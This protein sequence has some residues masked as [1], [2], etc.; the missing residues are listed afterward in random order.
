MNEF[1][2]GRAMTLPA[3]LLNKVMITILAGFLGR[4][5]GPI[6]S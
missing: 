3:Q 5:G 1:G 4:A 2:Q 6:K